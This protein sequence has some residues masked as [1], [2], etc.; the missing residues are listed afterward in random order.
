MTRKD[1]EAIA[2]AVAN[3]IRTDSTIQNRS[4]VSKDEWDAA[5]H[6]YRLV[7]ASLSGALSYGNP[8]FDPNRFQGAALASLE[9][10]EFLGETS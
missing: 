2:V 4:V 8:R 6:A 9:T 1:Y 5:A 10:A 7:A 3:A